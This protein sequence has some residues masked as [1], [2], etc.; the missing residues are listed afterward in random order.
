MPSTMGFTPILVILTS[1][2]TLI[3]PRQRR[4]WRSVAA[5]LLCMSAIGASI[6]GND[7]LQA[8]YQTLS[9]VLWVGFLFLP[10][11]LL[12]LV[13]Q[14]L[15]QE[16][17]AKARGLMS[18]T[19]WLHPFDGW[20][21]YPAMIQSLGSST[22][23]LEQTGRNSIERLA[24][25][26]Q[27]RLTGQWQGLIDWVDGRSDGSPVR[28]DANVQVMYL[29]ALGETH[30][31]ESMMRHFE[32]I[33]PILSQAGQQNHVQTSR[34]CVLAF[35]GQPD[36]VSWLLSQKLR[37]L[38]PAV[39]QYWQGTAY[40]MAGLRHQSQ[41]IFKGLLEPNNSRMPSALR[42]TIADRLDRP[43]PDNHQQL[44]PE[45][46]Q[47]IGR[48]QSRIIQE[49]QHP[50]NRR[51]TW[52]EAPVTYSLIAI[53]VL[54]GIGFGINHVLIRGI[55]VYQ[56]KI[57]DRIDGE[58]LNPL[59]PIVVQIA[60]WYEIS[61]LK[62]VEVIQGDWWQLITAAFLHG[63]TIHLLMNMLGLY[64]LG[65]IV[66]PLL[67]RT[68]FAIGYLLA[69]VG[70]MGLVTLLSLQ[71]LIKEQSV[72]G[73]SGAIMGVLGMMGAIFW[74]Q[75]RNKRDPM[76]A[77]RLQSIVMIVI[78]QTLFDAITPRVSMAGHLSGMIVGLVVGLFLIQT[79]P[80]N[81]ALRSQK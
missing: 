29:Q 8:P 16:N 34:L 62:P 33:E 64:I 68:R 41:P 60:Q 63:N 6:P 1:F 26:M 39:K 22:S 81:Q 31:P 40:W 74:Q 13:E 51:A 19:R 37:H 67:G 9:F 65:G 48:L 66:E 18:L 12:P 76:S 45:S 11:Q 52:K 28:R 2:I 44:S 14:L 69:A 36:S 10:S 4:G 77:Q 59:K 70:S 27:Y 72:V 43:A 71:N 56:S 46:R 42:S 80:V 55:V 30:Q 49:S 58:W 24:I 53:N 78:F 3:Q 15:Q 50:I 57:D 32:Q 7:P 35:T 23:R 17:F 25:V 73:A 5:S 47:V 21:R 38:T 20:W 54:I 61:V 79:L 75:W